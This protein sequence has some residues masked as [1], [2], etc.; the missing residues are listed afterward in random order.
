MSAASSRRRLDLVVRRRRLAMIAITLV[1]LLGA[2]PATTAS[3]AAP[4]PGVAD[5]R[6][7]AVRPTRDLAIR[8]GSVTP[9]QAARAAALA[10][11]VAAPAPLLSGPAPRLSAPAHASAT[12]TPVPTG[13]PI[14]PV[15]TTA[16]AG[17]SQAESGAEPPDEWVAVN[18]S[19]VVESVNGTVRIFDRL[20]DPLQTTPTWAFFGVPVGQEESDPRIIWDAFHGRWLGS[21]VSKSHD[22]SA[23]FIYLVVSET[24]D[25]R[26]AWDRFAFP[27]GG[28]LPDQP[29][30]AS[31][32]DKIV[33]T[34]NDFR[35]AGAF[36]G[37]AILAIDWT[38]ILAGG[39]PSFV[40]TGADSSLFSIRPAQVLS[41]S[42]DVHL[43][44]EDAVDAAPDVM[45][46]VLSGPATS[47][48]TAGFIDLT[49]G[50]PAIAAFSVPPPPRQTGGST[51]ALGV[52]ERPLDAVWRDGL[53]W[54]AATTA[55]TTSGGP[56]DGARYTELDTTT[57][58][59]T[60]PADFVVTAPGVDVYTPGLTV[61]AN[62]TLFA[63]FTT[64]SPTSN[65]DVEFST[66][67]AAAGLSVQQVL[68]QS[69]AAYHGQRWGD[70]AGVAADVI[71]SG[72]AWIVGELA[73]AD[74]SWVT[75]V[76]RLAADA[77]PPSAPSS[78]VS[79]ALVA[80]AT[81]ATAPGGASSAIPVRLSWGPASDPTSGVGGYS[82]SEQIDDTGAFALGQV[83]GLRLTH[84]LLL[85]HAYRYQVHAV[86]TAGNDGPDS[87]AVTVTPVLYEQTS[88]V[89]YGG[90]WATASSGRFSGGSTRTSSLAG[91]TATFSF[92]GSSV[93]FV[94]V[95]GPTSGSVR[96]YLDGRYVGT[97]SLYLAVG[98]NRQIVYASGTL[99]AGSHRLQVVV[100]GT[101]R[102]PRVDVDGFVILR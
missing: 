71:G 52:D 90:T 47:V 12:A 33:I 101:P 83:P 87:A 43:V 69:A 88:H 95:L 92:V 25:P 32:T 61:S 96:L 68:D 9:G 1:A 5:G 31:S 27:S 60:S 44:A 62:G 58:V 99:A 102:H 94:S 46:K 51:I 34:D 50:P 22:F 16:F 23:N 63:T 42:P 15:V 40:W 59:P 6:T 17:I 78:P 66:W 70:Y 55:T 53:L 79:V 98:R 86:D 35:G 93:A 11:R 41:P 36:L 100:V 73:A 37:A 56:A 30:I 54:F 8:L 57:A 21:L 89:T 24:A 64:S 65:P 14:D 7:A 18:A 38:S 72:A 20:G 2:L 77:D 3:A 13:T 28:I 4:A 10:P 26:G 39:P 75:D 84:T 81:L 76:A 49:T 97:R 91:A 82:I 45:Y 29:T 19:A 80:P 48:T 85:G 67:T 74:G